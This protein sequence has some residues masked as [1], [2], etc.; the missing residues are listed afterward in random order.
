M[1]NLST[2]LF[3]LEHITANTF[4]VYRKHYD[5]GLT[6]E[7]SEI[8]LSDEVIAGLEKKPHSGYWSEVVRQTVEENGA[9]YEKHRI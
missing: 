1:K 8:K 9:L 4:K 2:N 5:T 6:T 7:Y 3:I